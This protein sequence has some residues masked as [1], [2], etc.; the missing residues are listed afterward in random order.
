MKT[1]SN[2]TP[3]PSGQNQNRYPRQFLNLNKLLKFLQPVLVFPA[4]FVDHEL[5][6]EIGC[7]GLDSPN[8]QVLVEGLLE[9]LIQITASKH[10]C[11]LAKNIQTILLNQCYTTNSYRGLLEVRPLVGNLILRSLGIFNN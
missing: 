11:S 1:D 2:I 5:V 10:S 6:Q 3:D 4:V 9:I 8:L 7:A